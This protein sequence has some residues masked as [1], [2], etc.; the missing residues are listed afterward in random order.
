MLRFCL[1]VLLLG[2][3]MAIAQ[4]KQNAYE[5]KSSEPKY[6]V[7]FKDMLYF[8]ANDGIRGNELWR[9]DPK[10]E[11]VEQVAD[12]TP[13]EYGSA[14]DSPHAT[15]DALWFR[16]VDDEGAGELWRS[17]GEPG[18]D[19][20]RVWKREDESDQSGVGLILGELEAGMIFTI[21]DRGQSHEF[22]LL[23]P[24]GVTTSY[25]T[26]IAGAQLFAQN[27]GFTFHK[28]TL[29]FGARDGGV[30][31][32]WRTNGTPET[33]RLL[34]EFKNYPNPT[35]SL[36]EAGLFV[37]A[38]TEE[39]GIELW[40][41]LGE[42]EN[43]RQVLDIYPGKESSR[44]AD[45]RRDL[46]TGPGEAPRVYFAAT[47]PDSGR[48]L[49]RSDGT[50]EGTAL[51]Q[52][53]NPGRDSSNPYRIEVSPTSIYLV[54]STPETGTELWAAPVDENGYTTLQM[55][56]EGLAGSASSEPYAMCLNAEGQLY[57][58]QRGPDGEEFWY[59]DAYPGSARQLE[60]INPKGN[61]EPFWPA[62]LGDRVYF[63]AFDPVHGR[64]LWVDAGSNRPPRLVKD[65]KTDA[66]T[67]PSSS[68]TEFAAL[69]DCLLFAANDIA[70]GSEPWVSNGTKAGTVMLRDIAVGVPSSNPS[71]FTSVGLLAYFRAESLGH[72][73]ELWVTDGT[74]GGTVQVADIY[75]GE[76]GSNPD[77]LTVL[78]DSLIFMARNPQEGN[79]LWI[80]R[81]GREPTTFYYIRGGKDS[82]VARNFFVWKGFVYFQA[83]DGV[84]GEELWRTD[85]TTAGTSMVKD[86]VEA[87]FEPLSV[88]L[89][90]PVGDR[91]F[92][93][94]RSATTGRELWIWDDSEREPRLVRDIAPPS[95][96]DTRA[97]K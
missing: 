17:D 21:S 34:R 67:N 80:L 66:S 59:A 77:H 15:A 69:G 3:W 72:G 19:T 24:D 41:T 16:V 31:G 32:L 51:A 25:L 63:S 92:V 7:A 23:H 50:A 26:T 54:A 82:T 36:G 70:N 88:S 58:A 57:F 29:F 28:G 74:T 87:P 14:I 90:H 52:D 30:T 75:P 45:L 12:V 27:V 86:I 35:L 55:C 1:A 79:E 93:S 68:P 83:D 4:E 20:R 10:S 78:G 6:L 65:L 56:R 18:G 97:R 94:A 11:R 62:R 33:T 71:Q 37:I 38:E 96:L 95:L 47:H 81:P 48:E 85:G 49:W 9:Y 73:M 76:M 64:E 39:E 53:L 8:T 2:S 46:T 40:H 61:S 13:G 91:L 84:H 22:L 44:P 60:D 43:T 89:V 42:P 5:A